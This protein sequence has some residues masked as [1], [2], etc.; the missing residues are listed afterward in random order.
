[1]TYY[2]PISILEAAKVAGLSISGI[3]KAITSQRL[4]AIPLSGRGLMLCREQVAGEPFDEAEFRKL[5]KKY[6]SVP[7]ACD[8][9][10]KTDAMVLRDLRSGKIKGFKLNGKAWA[11]EKRSAEEE[12]REYLA[13]PVRRGQPRRIGE[14]RS[15]RVIRKKSLPRAKSSVRSR[16]R[17]K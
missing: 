8:I 1:M 6:V 12:F 7:E 5:C 9:V 10:C 15:P 4:I 16:P 14:S 2:R 11:V 13:S 17:G 3:V